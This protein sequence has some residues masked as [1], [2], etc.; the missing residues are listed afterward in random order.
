MLVIDASTA[1][2]LCLAPDGFATLH[3]EDLIAPPLI[4]SEVLSVLHEMRWR[5]DVPEEMAKLGVERHRQMPVRIMEPGELRAEAWRIADEF[6]WAKT[7]DAEYVALAKLNGCCLVTTDARLRRGAD[8]LG[9]V[10]TPADL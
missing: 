6:G 7:Y 1:V 10:I 5:G 2:D 9:F 8:R 4:L 3:E